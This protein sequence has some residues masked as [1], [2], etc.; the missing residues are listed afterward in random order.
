MKKGSDIYIRVKQITQKQ[1]ICSIN[2]YF[3]ECDAV[4]SPVNT[5]P[6]LHF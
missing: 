6:I 2:R 4:P 1:H 5:L 3:S